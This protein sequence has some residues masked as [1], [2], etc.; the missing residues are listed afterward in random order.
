M[1]SDYL[2]SVPFQVGGELI[3]EKGYSLRKVW[4][5][6]PGRKPERA[7]GGRT[8]FSLSSEKETT[9]FDNRL[10][11]TIVNFLSLIYGKVFFPH[12]LLQLNDERYL[13]F[14]DAYNLINYLEHPCFNS[15]PRIDFTLENRIDS[16]RQD[17]IRF[18]NLLNN[19]SP[20]LEAFIRALNF[21]GKA[22]RE[23]DD[24]QV[25]SFILFVSSI[26][27]LLNHVKFND[28]EL[29]DNDL[30]SLYQRIRTLVED[31]KEAEK[32]IR[33]IEQ[34]MF[35]IKRKFLAL[36]NRY[37]DEH[38][39]GRHDIGVEKEF[40]NKEGFESCLKAMY[41]ARSVYL[42]TGVDLDSSLKIFS[43]TLTEK[44]IA[45]PVNRRKKISEIYSN[46]PTLLFTERVC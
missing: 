32:I 37:V 12:G 21:Y 8:Y 40:Q 27:A 17:F 6:R 7:F 31:N 24:N 39:F 22:L 35:R 33:I 18:I 28:D 46:M 42:H 41:E 36:C 11:K 10:T 13:P 29:K 4:P 45:V 26:E 43:H 2:F 23:Y 25:T 15:N 19:Y 20:K 1:K 30:E 16:C 14:F 38:F 44:M 5:Y 3:T 34:R 9:E